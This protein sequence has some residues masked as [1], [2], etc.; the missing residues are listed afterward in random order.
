MPR[1]SRALKQVERERE[2][3]TWLD[4]GSMARTKSKVGEIGAAKSAALGERE[5]ERLR[6]E[7]TSWYRGAKR[8]LPWRRTRDPYA[9]WISEAMLQQTR[10]ETVVSYWRRF[11]ERFPNVE[12]LADADERDVLAAWSGLGYYRRARALRAAARAIVERHDGEFPSDANH[13][14][15]LPGIGPYTAGAVLSIAFDQPEALVDGNVARVFCRLFELDAPHESPALKRE[16]WSLARR[17]VPEHGGAG[18]WNQALMEF[19]ATICTPR[20]PNCASCPLERRCRASANGRALQLPRTKTRRAPV[21]VELE[22][23]LVERNG[24]VLLERRPEV[25]RMAGLWQLPTIETSSSSELFPKK[26]AN[27]ARFEALE[28]LG[29]VR[30]TITHH[31]IRV[32]VVRSRAPKAKLADPFAWFERSKLDSLATTGMTRKILGRF[33]C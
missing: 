16:L 14:R 8:D 25:G 17:L 15:E 5:V 1:Q 3:R 22:A 20:N 28:R 6:T 26:H 31:R 4:C 12:A 29:E 32:D 2:F 21:E 27:G 11:L 24:A 19:G 9:I 10:V 33:G 7:L 13:V 23:R 18:E 30:H